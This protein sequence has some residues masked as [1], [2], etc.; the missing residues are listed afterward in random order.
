MPAPV[1]LGARV[2]E[3]F[4]LKLRQLGLVRST[5][6]RQMKFGIVADEASRLSS[7]PAIAATTSYFQIAQL[8]I[9]NVQV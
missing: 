4:K 9:Y 6:A 8:P 5:R 2:M 3:S 7:R 1:T